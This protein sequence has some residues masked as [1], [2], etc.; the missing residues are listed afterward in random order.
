MKKVIL[1][2]VMIICVFMM[3]SCGKQASE[4]SDMDG[5]FIRVDKFGEGTSFMYD[6]FTKLVYVR[7][8]EGI[9]PYYIVKN[10][11]A[12]VARYGV[13]WTEANF[14]NRVIGEKDIY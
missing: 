12:V 7:F 2:I 6:T 1:I 4:K 5:F 9:S 11:E 13:N 10:G 14:S 3:T 8:D